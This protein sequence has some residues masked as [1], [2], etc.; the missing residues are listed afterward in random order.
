MP[1]QFVGSFASA[2]RM[3]SKDSTR[4]QPGFFNADLRLKRSSDLSDQLEAFRGAVDS[5]TF[6]PALKAVLYIPTSRKAT[7]A[8]R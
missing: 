2:G 3:E 7:P 8:V 6:R 4:R 1:G 5:E